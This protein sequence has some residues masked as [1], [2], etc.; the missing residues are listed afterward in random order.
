MIKTIQFYKCLSISLPLALVAW[1]LCCFLPCTP[2]FAAPIL[3]LSVSSGPV[4]TP[5]T[6][7][8]TVFQSYEG[9]SIHILFDAT[10]ITP[11][12]IPASGS[13]ST[14]WIIPADAAGGVHTLGAKRE[15]TDSSFFISAPFTVDTRQLTLDVSQGPTGTAIILAGTGYYI[16][17]PVTIEYYNPAMT[18]IGAV[19]ASSSGKFSKTYTIPDGIA[20]FHRFNAS[21][22][23][24][25]TAEVY[26]KVIPDIVMDVDA[27]AP[28]ELVN[29][30]GSGFGTATSVS[31]SLNTNI[32]AM[33]ITDNY[34]NFQADFTIPELAIASY[35]LIARDNLGNKVETEFP[36]TAGATLS[37]NTGAVGKPVTVNGNGFQTGSAVTITYDDKPVAHTTT[38][39]N[40]SFT[41]TFDIPASDGG[42][43][44]INISDG[45]TTRHYAF[46]V[47]TTPPIAPTPQSPGNNSI[48]GAFTVFKWLA[49]TDPSLPVTYSLE[50]A[51][52]QSFSSVILRKEGL[53]ETQYTMT[54]VEAMAANTANTAYYWRVM[55]ADG[56]D[57]RGGW[58]VV[59]SYS[60]APP[61][62]P[63]LSLPMD[64][65]AV[66]FP[67]SLSWTEATALSGPVT[68]HLQVSRN[69]VFSELLIDEKEITTTLYTIPANSEFIFNKKI[70]YY[71]RVKSADNAH[72]TSDWSTTGS[73]NI[74]SPGFP[75][76][77]VITLVSLAAV[78]IIWLVYRFRRHKTYQIPE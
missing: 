46:A 78:L 7:T 1:I 50:V 69:D 65:A 43:H 53:T 15:T 8:G 55:A 52:N 77:A 2:I 72:N 23:K 49:V 12:T 66:E 22:T 76:W 38:D 33:T 58:S 42:E 30:K 32:T 62:A 14:S 74:V 70:P 10:E 40:G 27:G 54:A 60:I 18:N 44:T 26:F 57:N 6:I 47:E 37:E 39:N 68:Y 73:F 19:T 3:K 59:W 9:D 41:I 63:A 45:N 31:I 71:W 11:I 61:S 35:A 29:I 25:N 13:F 36:V 64:G 17:E 20:G 24:G 51:N 75:A 34:G 16:N 67:I 4:G 21:N 5:V 56:A 48:T 28:G